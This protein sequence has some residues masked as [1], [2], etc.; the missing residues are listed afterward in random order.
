MPCEGI[1]LRCAICDYEIE[2]ED[3]FYHVE[4]E[5]TPLDYC[6]YMAYEKEYEDTLICHG[7]TEGLDNMI[8]VSKHV[9]A[10]FGGGILFY[11]LEGADDSQYN[12]YIELFLAVAKATEWQRVCTYRGFNE[13]QEGEYP[14]GWFRVMQFW[15]GLGVMPEWVKEVQAL[16]K[17]RRVILVLLRNANLLVQYG[18]VLAKN[19]DAFRISRLLQKM[20]QE[21]QTFCM[22]SGFECW[23]WLVRVKT[24]NHAERLH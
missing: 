18:A 12:E 1:H 24:I 5:G 20:Y 13:L 9:W 4:D 22:D 3:A 7:C 8:K 14:H 21:E 10:K 16:Y 23:D 17:E 15:V 19:E 2:D 11:Y 6:G